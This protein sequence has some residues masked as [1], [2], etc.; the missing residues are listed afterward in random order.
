M[1]ISR[2]GPEPEEPEEEAEEEAEEPEPIAVEVEPQ[3]EPEI[4]PIQH[5]IIDE[6]DNKVEE[7]GGVEADVL[8]CKF[9]VDNANAPHLDLKFHHSSLW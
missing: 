8:S 3:E 9:Q 7:G 6:L 4:A 2:Y 5:L 1:F